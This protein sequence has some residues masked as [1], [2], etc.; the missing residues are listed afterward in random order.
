MPR[1]ALAGF[2]SLV[3]ALALAAPATAAITT[4][5]IT[6]PASINQLFTGT[7]PTFTPGQITVSGT[8]DGTTGDQIRL[9]QY[10]TAPNSQQGVGPAVNV[11]ANGNWT[12]D[13]PFGQ[14]GGAG[15]Y[16]AGMLF[17]VPANN[18]PN[19][20]DTTKFHGI[21]ATG[22]FQV[23]TVNTGGQPEDFWLIH[24]GTQ[25]FFDAYGIADC[26]VC[27]T[28]VYDAPS[29]Q[30]G[31]YVWYGAGLYNDDQGD[32]GPRRSYLQVDGNNVL[33]PSGARYR[34]LSGSPG[35]VSPSITFTNGAE[36]KVDDLEPALKCTNATPFPPN[37][38]ADCGTLLA[39]GVQDKMTVASANGGLRQIAT[40]VF[41]ATDGQSHTLSV[42]LPA[43]VHQTSG[44]QFQVPWSS[45]AFFDLTDTAFGAPPGP[46][47][48]FF[49]EDKADPNGSLTNP[50]GAA[51]LAPAPQYVQFAGNEFIAAYAASVSPGHDFVITQQFDT[52]RTLAAAQADGAAARDQL[53]GPSVAITSPAGVT[54][55]TGSVHVTG[56]ASDSESATTV[57]VN[58]VA[59]P[60][61]N[62]AW[63]ADI[64]LAPGNQTITAVA[65]DGAGNTAQATQAVTVS[66]LPDTKAP[67]ITIKVPSSIKL[68][69][70]RKS[71][72]KVTATCTEACALAA[73]LLA[74]ASKAKLAKAGDLTLATAS[75][76]LG[77][78]TRKLTLKV[79]K[80]LR[81]SLRRKA[82]LRVS[83]T[84]TDAAGNRATTTKKVK[85]K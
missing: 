31:N 30:R 26:G 16:G 7:G 41:S 77:T 5:T 84:A 13:V 10:G 24:T 56:T 63:A 72:I 53:Q 61:S 33:F 51:T 43:D 69:A 38:N 25:G 23:I 19:P 78:G 68:A 67:G 65:T 2:A 70:L 73:N 36:P 8:S 83:V 66:A 11:A 20:P 59:A 46:A 81:S 74:T 45:S 76:K 22:D 37:G 64:P 12:V 75:A 28:Q 80:K 18:I 71:G 17:A 3:A 55:P 50:I 34:S 85:V 35:F 29:G 42:H 60:V 58:G 40:H 9:I 32:Y 79:S 57:K 48:V 15:L 4:A 14:T 6:S 39:S 52:E 54:V 49:R 21:P 1:S 27:D 82:K 62:G 47:T 44:S